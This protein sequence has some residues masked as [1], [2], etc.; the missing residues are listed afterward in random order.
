ADFGMEEATPETIRQ[1]QRSVERMERSAVLSLT[2]LGQVAARRLRC[3]L[4]LLHAAEAES[5]ISDVA[6]RRRRV[7]RLWPAWR[8]TYRATD[9]ARKLAAE[10]A[11]AEAL[12]ERIGAQWEKLE[13]RCATED[14]LAAVTR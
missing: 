4:D 12:L 1:Q 5:R 3:A 9:A 11:V 6:A 10:T 2:P 7:E 14:A 8:A 13:T